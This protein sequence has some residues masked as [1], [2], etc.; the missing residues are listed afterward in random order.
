MRK[1]L[2]A[3]LIAAALPTVALAATPAPTDAPPPARS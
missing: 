3:L 2:T 1:T